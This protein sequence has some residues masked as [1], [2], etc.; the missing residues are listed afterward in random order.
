LTYLQLPSDIVRWCIRG[1]QRQSLNPVTT[2]M[3]CRVQQSI[4]VMFVTPARIKT[5]EKHIATTKSGV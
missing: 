1:I 5:E 2:P 3:S 4:L